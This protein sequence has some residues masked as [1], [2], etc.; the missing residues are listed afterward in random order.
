MNQNRLKI[1]LSVL[2]TIVV[3]ILGAQTA[4]QLH[5]PAL[6]VELLGVAGT[7]L[8]MFGASP[9][10]RVIG[11]KERREVGPRFPSGVYAKPSTE[12]ITSDERPSGK[13]PR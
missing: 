8:G 6:A 2:A 1:A 13:M 11:Q 4:G 12:E 9:I 10:G 7:V 5:L 3:A